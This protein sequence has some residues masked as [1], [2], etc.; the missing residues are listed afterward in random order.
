EGETYSEFKNKVNTLGVGPGLDNLYK[1]ID[2]K[3]DTVYSFD[4]EKLDDNTIIDQSGNGYDATVK[5]GQLT[6]GQNGK[7][8][9]FNG[10]GYI[11]AQHKALKWPYTVTFDLTI[12]QKQTGDITL[13]E[14]KMPTQECVKKDGQKT[15]QETR[16]IVLEEQDDGTYRLTYSREGFHFEHNYTFKKGQPYRIAFSSDESKP[17]GGEYAKW[18][19]PTKLYVNGEL[20]STLQGPEKPEGFEGTWWVDSASMNLPLEKI[21]QNLVGSIDNFNLYNRLLSDDEIKELGG[22]ENQEPEP[23]SKNLALNKPIT[24]SSYKNDSLVAKNANDGSLDTR[25]ASNYN[26]S[27]NDPFDKE[28]WLCIDLKD[29]YS[30]GQ[31]KLSWENAYAKEYTIQLSNDGETFTD[32]LKV[33]D[34]D[35]GEDILDLSGAKGRYIRIYCTQAVPSNDS[36]K[37][38]YGYSLLEVEVYECESYQVTFDVDG[39][40]TVVTLQKE[41]GV[42]GDKMLDSPTKEGYV[43]KEWNT[44]KDGTGDVITKQ[45]TITGNITV[46]AIFTVDMSQLEDMISKAENE[47]KNSNYSQ[48]TRDNLKEKLDAAKAV[49]DNKYATKEDV[50]QAISALEKAIESLKLKDADYTKVNEAIKKANALNK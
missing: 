28:E 50:N 39:K 15:G 5:N 46:Y 4:M 3:D 30:L 12:D 11:E 8:L 18:N 6:N 1:E 29:T 49:L 23:V 7:Q 21:G 27:T 26:S 40:Q 31:V 34:G 16:K 25:W 32:V 43:F 37:W 22:F 38:N 2:S 9:T 47:M 10:D 44:K 36:W 42:L 33:T 24:A 19:Q 45:T 41:D 13:F 14:E 20:V 48:E 35:G 17:T